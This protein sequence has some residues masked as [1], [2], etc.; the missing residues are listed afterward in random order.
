MVM[1]SMVLGQDIDISNQKNFVVVRTLVDDCIPVTGGTYCGYHVPQLFKAHNKCTWPEQKRGM[2]TKKEC[3]SLQYRYLFCITVMHIWHQ[4]RQQIQ[5]QRP[6][7]N[8]TLPSQRT[9]LN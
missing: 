7:S 3:V 1:A 8:K 9:K 2:H 6:H 5:W 4:T